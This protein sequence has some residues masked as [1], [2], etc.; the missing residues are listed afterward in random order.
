MAVLNKA[1]RNYLQAEED[2]EH[3][4]TRGRSQISNLRRCVLSIYDV[5]RILWCDLIFCSVSAVSLTADT[6]SR[7]SLE[8]QHVS[9]VASC[10]GLFSC[11]CLS[12]DWLHQKMDF[13]IS[14]W[15]LHECP[16]LRFTK[17]P[18]L[19]DFD[20]ILQC[21]IAFFFS[22]SS[23]HSKKQDLPPQNKKWLRKSPF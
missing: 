14:T 11:V 15:F 1:G 18:R 13:C 9:V 22:V 16:R 2:V 5:Q 3:R 23:F 6:E 17:M 12:K 4:R 20:G 8:L 7:P 21:F 19:I 10:S